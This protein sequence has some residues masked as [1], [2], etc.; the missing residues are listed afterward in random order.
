MHQESGN[1]VR[2]TGVNQNKLS[3]SRYGMLPT[4]ALNVLRDLAVL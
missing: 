1:F 2:K 4:F 3:G